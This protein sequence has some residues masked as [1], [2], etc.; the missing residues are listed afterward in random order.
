M[1]CIQC[2]RESE[3]IFRD[4][5]NKVGGKCIDCATKIVQAVQY[6]NINVYCLSG[7]D[8]NLQRVIDE[9]FYPFERIDNVNWVSGIKDLWVIAERD[10]RNLPRSCYCP[11]KKRVTIITDEFMGQKPVLTTV[12]E[13]LH[14]KH[15]HEFKRFCGKDLHQVLDE[16]KYRP[17]FN[18]RTD[19]LKREFSRISIADAA[20]E[21][22]A[23]KIGLISEE[24]KRIEIEYKQELTRNEIQER[25]AR[26]KSSTLIADLGI[27]LV[28]A[29]RAKSNSL[30]QLMEKRINPFPQP[31]REA[32]LSWAEVALKADCLN[33][34]NW[35]N[36]MDEFEEL[37]EGM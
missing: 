9:A 27:G 31:I 2:S 23:E 12:H 3:I 34:S 8:G 14:V 28:V 19:F 22:F 4:G 15:M 32:T 10:L 17:P 5:L 35:E 26:V 21:S 18:S 11:N 13:F 20:L 25:S 29:K 37:I 24:V 30:L 33:T 6:R 7:V 36:L 1:K 16:L